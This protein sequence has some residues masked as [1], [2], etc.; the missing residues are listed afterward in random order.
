MDEQGVLKVVPV[1]ALM[2]VRGC[3]MLAVLPVMGSKAG[4]GWSVRFPIA[5]A[6]ALPSFAHIHARPLPELVLLEGAWLTLREFVIGALC[7]AFFLPLFA[8]PRT[9][10]ALI[11]QQAGATSIQLFD[12]GSAEG[13]TTPFADLFEQC[14]LY[15]FV[16]SGGLFM[17]G[18]MYAYSYAA[19]PVG[20]QSW[21]DLR[22]FATALA[23]DGFVV[24]F[25]HAIGH[26]APYVTVLLLCEYS[27]GLIG[28]AAPQINVVTTSAALKMWFVLT[29]IYLGGSNA[30]DAVP[31]AAGRALQDG[32]AF[33]NI[34][35]NQ[36]LGVENRP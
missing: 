28:R 10:G 18:E 7:G 11:D 2:W 5:M 6:I 21:P 30:F 12:P 13:S 27:I 19:W 9:A 1:L 20:E 16:L 24:L 22:A 34:G 32:V 15:A 8:V 17:L 26:A 33:L 35:L 14:A 36:Q 31:R 25:T 3:G 23:P 4:Q 29:A